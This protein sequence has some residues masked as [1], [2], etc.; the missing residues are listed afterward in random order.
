MMKSSNIGD[1]AE[2]IFAESYGTVG[3]LVPEEPITKK[4]PCPEKTKNKVKIPPRFKGSPFDSSVEK[5]YYKMKQIVLMKT[6]RTL[7]QMIRKFKILFFS[8]M[9]VLVLGLMEWHYLIFSVIS[10]FPMEF[11]LRTKSCGFFKI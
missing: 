10:L 8:N 1:I 9:K 2:E 5:D 4:I 11:I 3:N 6:K 7:K